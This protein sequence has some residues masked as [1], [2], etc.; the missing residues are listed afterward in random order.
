MHL[1]TN[2]RS[3]YPGTLA[4]FAKLQVVTSHLGVSTLCDSVQPWDHASHAMSMAVHGP[5]NS[6]AVRCLGWIF[7]ETSMLSETGEFAVVWLLW[8]IRSLILG[9]LWARNIIPPNHG[10]E[11]CLI[12]ISPSKKNPTSPEVMGLGGD[13]YQ[14]PCQFHCA[15]ASASTDGGSVSLMGWIPKMGADDMYFPNKSLDVLE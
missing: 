9:I 3:I 4:I 1:L 7:C 10:H 14:L 13:H 11:S 6:M 15:L 2:P 12:P 8:P 5:M